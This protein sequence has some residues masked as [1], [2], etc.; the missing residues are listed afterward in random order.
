MSGKITITVKEKKALERKA[1]TGWALYFRADEENY[2]LQEQNYNLIKKMKNV[3]DTNEAHKL[4]TNLEDEIRELYNVLKRK[5][6]CPI[7]FDEMS[8]EDFVLSNCYC[9]TK[10]C[11][12]CYEKLNEC[13][14]CKNKYKNK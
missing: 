2:I 9:R 5:I 11:K 4:P 7:C 10:Y 3:I 13:A 12:T 8:S 14:V 1:K 6:E